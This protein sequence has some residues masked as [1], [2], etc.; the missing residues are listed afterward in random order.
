MKKM[1][2]K[3]MKK[4]IFFIE[5][6][7]VITLRFLF[8]KKEEGFSP[9]REEFF[10][11]IS[12]SSFFERI[13]YLEKKI[14]EKK[15]FNE[16]L[17]NSE[18]ILNA[19]KKFKEEHY[20]NVMEKKKYSC[21]LYVEKKKEDEGFFGWVPTFKHFYLISLEDKNYEERKKLCFLT[22]DESRFLSTYKEEFNF[23]KAFFLDDF[24]YDDRYNIPTDFIF[25]FKRKY[26]QK[27]R[28]NCPHG[29]N[30]VCPSDNLCRAHKFIFF[31]EKIFEAITHCVIEEKIYYKYFLFKLKKN[32]YLNEISGWDFIPSEIK[33]LSKLS[34]SKRL[35]YLK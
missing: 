32:E 9:V 20:K 25:N 2:N 26:F 14:I 8:K 34:Y 11:Q 4:R 7:E 18:K 19:I 5:Y 21:L 27:I 23:Y 17:L 6:E 16:E 12:T 22:D 1:I 15:Q 24:F 30:F 33:D 10:F 13:N 31:I 35:S 29:V 28:S 3:E